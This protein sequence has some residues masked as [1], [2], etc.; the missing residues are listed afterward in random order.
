VTDLLQ[1]ARALEARHPERRQRLPQQ[2]QKVFRRR[3][4]YLPQWAIFC[5]VRQLVVVVAPQEARWRVLRTGRC[6]S[7][8][9]DAI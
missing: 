2:D 6:V 7:P 9:P 3:S 8:A 4:F 5:L 1:A